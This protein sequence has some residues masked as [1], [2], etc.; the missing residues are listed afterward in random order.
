METILSLFTTILLIVI[1]R[2]N[3]LNHKQESKI[4]REIDYIWE[5]MMF[6]EEDLEEILD[7]QARIAHNLGKNDKKK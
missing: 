4:K 3:W 1:L 2:V 6:I 7:T 5:H